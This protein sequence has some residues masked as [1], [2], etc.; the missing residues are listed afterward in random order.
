MLSIL[1][2]A[3]ACCPNMGSEP[4]MAWNWCIHLAKH[5][6]LHIIT[7]GEFKENI[8]SALITLPQGKNMH[9]YYNPVSDKVR[10]MCWNQGNWLFYAHYRK[11][12]YKT[13]EIATEIIQKTPIDIIHQLNMIG[14]REPGY[15]WKIKNIP[16]VW[17]PIGGLKQFPLKY[18]NGA[19]LKVKL[20]NYLKN[21]INILQLRYSKRVN[22]AFQNADILISSIPDS[23]VAI[24]KHK[25]IETIIIPE[26]GCYLSETSQL[27]NFD[28]QE[29]HVL[30]VGKFDFR[31]QL[32]IALKALQATKNKK[33][34]LEVFGKGTAVQENEAKKLTDSIGISDQ[35]I[36]HGEQSNHIVLQAMQKSQLFLFTS[37]SEDTSTVVL[38]AISKNLPVLCFDTCGFGAIINKKIG[39]KIKLS[40]PQQSIEDFA[41]HLN[42]LDAHRETLKEL[43][44]NC[45]KRSQELSWEN[46]AKQIIELYSK[47]LQK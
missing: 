18:L 32:I 45:K 1:I 20:T 42:F 5:C 8:E 7:E 26:T 30:W 33:I 21:H 38:E 47:V 19:S 31:K 11:W 12:Q 6:E 16:F 40:T 2:N 9:F 13:Y 35:V 10:R 17:G 4:G 36:W 15:L 24:K 23:Y 25:G 22:A 44:N 3:Y 14:F 34:I 46:K 27:K 39:R 29:L 43:S 41:E 37:V 28:T